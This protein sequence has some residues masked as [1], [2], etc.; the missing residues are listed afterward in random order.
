MSDCLNVVQCDCG[1]LR[2]P[3]AF[4]GWDDY[5]VFA[6]SIKTVSSFVQVPVTMPHS[7]VGLLECWYRCGKCQTVWRLVEPDPP[8]TGVWEHV[9]AG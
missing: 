5:D 7:N 6:A 3:G 8:F 2:E 4:A 9:S 1:K